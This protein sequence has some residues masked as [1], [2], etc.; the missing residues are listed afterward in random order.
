MGNI[1]PI[2]QKTHEYVSH[3]TCMSRIHRSG[4]NP[5]TGLTLKEILAGQI[6]MNKDSCR[7]FGLWG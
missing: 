3:N 4:G 6:S 5:Q 7:K 1:A 2:N